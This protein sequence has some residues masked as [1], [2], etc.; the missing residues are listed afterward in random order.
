M[1]S[2]RRSSTVVDT[3]RL[4]SS[5]ETSY[6][7]LL[8]S[9]TALAVQTHNLEKLVEKLAG[10]V[11]TPPPADKAINPKGSGLVTRFERLAE[12]LQVTANRNN[13]LTTLIANIIGDAN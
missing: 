10:S 4:E 5:I 9:V 6:I 7:R 3:S 13:E 12:E 1:P 11:P 2:S 8:N